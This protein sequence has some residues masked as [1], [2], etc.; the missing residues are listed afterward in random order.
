MQNNFQ[1]SL[2]LNDKNDNGTA[3]DSFI[4]VLIKIRHC[5]IIKK[6]NLF[7][8]K[9]YLPDEYRSNSKAHDVALLELETP[10]KFTEE[11][12]KNIKPA[13]LYVPDQK[14]VEKNFTVIGFGKT[15]FSDR[16]SWLMKASV[17]ETPLEDC[18]EKFK[19]IQTRVQ[20]KDTQICAHNPF[21]DS[22]LG[23]LKYFNCFS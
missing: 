22:C 1:T 16:S 3:F 17:K 18:K 8:Q 19:H 13:C 6:R 14:N 9:I 5:A 21:Q 2:D 4:K 10:V 12:C 23:Q 15:E 20:I 7:L 11:T